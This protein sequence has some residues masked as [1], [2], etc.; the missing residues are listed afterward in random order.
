MTEPFLLTAPQAAPRLA[1][2]HPAD[3]RAELHAQPIAYQGS[4]RRLASAILPLIPGGIRT[5]YEPFV[6]SGALALAVAHQGAAQKFTLGDSLFP[7]VQLWQ[8]IVDAP[9]A[10]AQT[11]AQLWHAQQPDP[12]ALFLKVRAE[13]NL[14]QDPGKLLYLLAR[15]VKNAVRFNRAGA[16]NQAPD[17][18][19]LG[20]RPE[21]MRSRLTSAHQALAGR[22]AIHACD[23]E[24]LLQQVTPEDLAYLDPPYVG[25]SGKVNQRYQQGLDL[26]R[27]IAALSLANERQIRYLVSLDGRTGSRSYGQ[28]LPASLGL[29]HLELAAGRSSQATLLGRNE[30]TFESLYVS[31]ALHHSLLQQG[32]W[33]LPASAADTG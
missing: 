3:R 13:F 24:V 19:R 6:G 15:C 5:W 16:F 23:Y 10:L 18:R 26:P 32:R 11:Y 1:A 8:A 9:D 27:F 25:V 17:R 20:T 28:P 4:K 33:P 7:L 31:P 12:T 30:E 29:V 21:L 14:D 2:R 22:V